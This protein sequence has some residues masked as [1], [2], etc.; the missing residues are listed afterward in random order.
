[1]EGSE[2]LTDLGS[3][4]VCAETSDADVSDV[5]VSHAVLGK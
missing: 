4:G 2:V 3:L 5:K 1:M